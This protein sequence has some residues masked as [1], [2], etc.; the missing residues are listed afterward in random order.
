MQVLIVGGAGF[1]GAN[2]VRRCL[3]EPDVRVTVV[4]S[5]DP[6]FMSRRESL[7]DVPERI[8]FLQGDLLSETD[9]SAAVVD[10][11]V[12]FDCAGQTSHPVSMDQPYLDLQLNCLGSLRL[13][14]AVRHHNPTAS[15][16]FT[17]SST[18]V[19]PAVSR[20]VDEDHPERP[21]D[22]YSANKGVAEKY[23]AIY[24][25]KYG[26]RTVSLR[27]PNLFG[28]Y[29]K[30]DARF[31]FINYFIGL[32]RSGRP[33]QVF[34]EGR[35]TRNVMYVEDAAEVLWRVAGDARLFGSTYFATSDDHRS[36]TEIAE[37]VDE[38]FAGGG[39]EHV[40]WSAGR[41]QIEVGNVSLSSA[42]LREISGWRPRFDLRSGLERMRDVLEP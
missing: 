24:H 28:P 32:A 12:I 26:L 27:L 33:I 30:P 16:V 10:Q 23:F 36:I 41:E 34:G 6:R 3:Q 14:E 42:R 17:S 39:V 38:C 25:E 4:D 35:Q 8:Q 22:V 11:D 31:G 37:A 5:L 1:L 15:V 29:G 40:A 13:L 7:P 21:R 20:A 18:V 2:L 19:G 9:I